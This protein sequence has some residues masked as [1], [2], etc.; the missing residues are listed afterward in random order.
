MKI[1]KKK[2]KLGQ[3]YLREEKKSR[4]LH[5]SSLSAAMDPQLCN[6]AGCFSIQCPSL[7]VH[8]F[9]FPNKNL[10]SSCLAPVSI[11]DIQT[12]SELLRKTT[13]KTEGFLI[14]SNEPCSLTCCTSNG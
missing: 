6:L 5:L 12:A 4:A 8:T 14:T 3:L 1:K 11:R 7:S 10:F 9:F 13:N 2:K